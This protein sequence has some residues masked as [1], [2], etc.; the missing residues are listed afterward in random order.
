MIPIKRMFRLEKATGNK[1]NFNRLYYKREEAFMKQIKKQMILF[2]I[3]TLMLCGTTGISMTLAPNSTM[4]GAHSGR[5]DANGGHRDNQNKSGL[6]SYH[7]HC[8]GHPAH[9]HK[10][11]ECPYNSEG[12]TK[13]KA[14]TKVK[15]S[16]LVKKVQKA[17]NKR[18]YKCGKADGIMGSKTKKALKKFQKA[19][20]LK[21][22]GKIGKKV[23]R[24][25]N[26]K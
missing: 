5:T 2:M 13:S 25:L 3:F 20:G 18:G 21:V 15:T 1:Y 16:A 9:L 4:V 23:K 17:L 22:T 12:I 8:G 26:I 6:G 10:N 7:Y 24:A 14:I 19:Q 11:G